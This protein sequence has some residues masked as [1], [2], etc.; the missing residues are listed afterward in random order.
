MMYI[1]KKY[2]FSDLGEVSIPKNL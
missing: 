2:Y 1:A